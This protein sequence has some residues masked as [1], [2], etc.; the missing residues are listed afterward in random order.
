MR[1]ALVL[2][3]AARGVAFG[4]EGDLFRAVRSGDSA[5]VQI[6]IGNGASV[7]ARDS[8][9]ETPLLVAIR[10]PARDVIDV[11]VAAH[12]EPNLASPSGLTPLI[13]ASHLGREDLVSL[14]IGA[15]AALDLRDRALGTALDAAQRGGHRRIASLLRARGARGSGKS[16]GDSV[17]V[18]PWPGGEGFCGRIRDAEANDF[19]VDVTRLVGCDGTC[20]ARADCSSGEAVGGPGGIAVGSRVVVKSWCLTKT[21]L[22]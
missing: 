9:G 21:A 22:P 16:V 3:L 11:L 4:S 10:F 12:A 7:D 13:L 20:P 18:Q 17:C 6:L 15:G 1:L 2:A 14:L 19:V 5:A 8:H